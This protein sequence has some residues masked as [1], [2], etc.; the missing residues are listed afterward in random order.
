MSSDFCCVG[1]SGFLVGYR[2]GRKEIP[3]FVK[4]QFLVQLMSKQHEVDA[5]L[6]DL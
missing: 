4:L 5:G 2:A 3:T 6:N 1:L